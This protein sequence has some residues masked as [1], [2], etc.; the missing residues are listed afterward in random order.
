MRKEL[1][2]EIKDDIEALQVSVS[3]V[4]EWEDIMS[5]AIKNLSAEKI[6]EKKAQQLAEYLEGMGVSGE[7][8]E[9]M[10]KSS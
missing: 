9:M 6:K 8:D 7:A 2:S 3:Q 1:G 4:S 5:S 10:R